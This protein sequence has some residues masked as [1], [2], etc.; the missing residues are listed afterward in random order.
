MEAASGRL[1]GVMHRRGP[2]TKILSQIHLPH[3]LADLEAPAPIPR[4]FDKK[5]RLQNRFYHFELAGNKM[6][7]VHNWLLPTSLEVKRGNF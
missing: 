2:R 1:H 6:R 5:Y 4:S 3:M 7:S